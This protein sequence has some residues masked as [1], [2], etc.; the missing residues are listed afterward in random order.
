MSRLALRA[1][2][3]ASAVATAAIATPAFLKTPLPCLASTGH[4][5][6]RSRTMI[7]WLLAIKIFFLSG[8]C[9]RSTFMTCDAHCVHG[10]THLCHAMSMP[11]PSPK[12]PFRRTRTRKGGISDDRRACR[13]VRRAPP[14]STSF[15]GGVKYCRSQH[16]FLL[17]FCMTW[18]NMNSTTKHDFC[19][20]A[21]LA[22]AP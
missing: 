7:L 4:V 12:S 17:F 16:S 6:K 13:R 10:I 15:F 8:T 9:L 18:Q 2:S 5:F 20:H 3:R 1:A 14:E 11:M 22:R 21:G 19:M